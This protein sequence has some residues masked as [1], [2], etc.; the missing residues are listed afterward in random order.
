MSIVEAEEEKLPT[1]LEQ[2][3]DGAHARVRELRQ[4]LRELEAGKVLDAQTNLGQLKR[5][6]E[7]LKKD[8]AEAQAEID[9]AL[10][11]SREPDASVRRERRDLEDRIG[12]T[13]RAIEG[14]E[15]KLADAAN[16]R[17]GGETQV[18]EAMG[19]VESLALRVLIANAVLAIQ[20]ERDAARQRL[21]EYERQSLALAMFLTR[22]L[23]SLQGVDH[24]AASEAINALR[25]G[26]NWEMPSVEA[27]PE[28]VLKFAQW[29]GYLLADPE[30]TGDGNHV[31]F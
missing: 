5:R 14:A 2:Q 24:A 15:K 6:R 26:L 16:V 8:L 25:G 13:D 19:R 7:Q 21:V 23:G 27:K 1:V 31:R 10:A 9:E 18:A 28:D 22:K 30:A 17:A 3:L 20:V 11:D 12:D 29:L 4:K